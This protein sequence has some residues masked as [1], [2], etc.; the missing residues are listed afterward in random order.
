MS[1]LDR[2][3]GHATKRNSLL[4]VVVAVVLLGA[5]VGFLGDP[6]GGPRGP[7]AVDAEAPMVVEPTVRGDR[8]SA[9]L[10]GI[11]AGG[12]ATVDLAGTPLARGSVG[13]RQLD[14]E[15]AESRPVTLTSVSRSD[16]APAGTPDTPAE[17][18]LGYV[19][20]DHTETGDA[21]SS[22]TLTVQVARSTL[23][24]RNAGPGDV[25]VYRFSD[26]AW[27]ALPTRLVESVGSTLTYEAT[28]P[29][30]S[31]FAVAIQRGGTDLSDAT[32][33]PTVAPP[34]TADDAGTATPTASPNETGTAT[35]T[36]TPTEA[37]TGTESPTPTG[38]PVQQVVPTPEP[39]VSG[40][41]DAADPVVE[42]ASGQVREVAGGL[43]G[44]VEWQGIGD[45]DSAVVVVQT[46]VPEWG[47]AEVDRVDVTG[48]T[49]Q[50][51]S[52]AAVLGPETTYAAGG[53]AAVFDVDA[54]G[55]TVEYD[56]EVSVTVV[57]FDGSVSVERL[58]VTEAVT[59]RVTNLPGDSGVEGESNEDGD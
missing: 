14:I 20:I 13:L 27:T 43:A 26:G 19:S 8:V 56:A 28:S 25:V 33:T 38:D 16:A 22:V 21:V 30:L 29:G 42:T 23:E 54:D 46:W 10:E 40:T 1:R 39:D 18:A 11:E 5:G 45:V 32:R 37:P 51:I 53:R 31:V 6:S 15:F 48:V 41:L 4:V 49:G 52:L 2:L 3:A 47:W 12:T 7:P 17:A 44:A 35:S 59:V 36:G 24:A 57:L 34:G 55:A 50:S 9:S 58:T